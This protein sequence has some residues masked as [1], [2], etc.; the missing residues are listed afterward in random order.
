MVQSSYSYLCSAKYESID[1]LD[2]VVMITITML[3]RRSDK[4]SVHS[5]R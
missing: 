5:E 1:L 4:R 3:G 2:E